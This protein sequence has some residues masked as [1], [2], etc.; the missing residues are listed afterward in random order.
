VRKTLFLLSVYLTFGH[1]LRAA[2]Q[3][4][5]ELERVRPCS[6]LVGLSGLLGAGEAAE[7]RPVRL[8]DESHVPVI[9]MS[10]HRDPYW[11]NLVGA[12][13]DEKVSAIFAVGAISMKRIIPLAANIKSKHVLLILDSCFSG[14]LMKAA[15]EAPPAAAGA[16]ADAPARLNIERAGETAGAL[17]P[18]PHP[19]PLPPIPYPIPTSAEACALSLLK[20]S[21]LKQRSLYDRRLT[22]QLGVFNLTNRANFGIHARP[23]P[24]S[25]QL[26]PD[27]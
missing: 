25:A 7:A 16:S 21:F 17:P 26:R 6:G 2:A 20:N 3:T 22:F 4:P 5:W 13:S 14:S 10:D 12:V 19:H 11:S 15:L 1:A 18:Y 9:G 24:R 27:H 23:P 8:Y